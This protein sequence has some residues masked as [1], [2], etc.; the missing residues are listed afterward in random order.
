MSLCRERSRSP[1]GRRG[2]SADNVFSIDVECVATGKTHELSARSP[3]S[4]ALVDGSGKVIY[5]AMI[6]PVEPVVSYLTPITGVTAT[7]LGVGVPLEEAI[8]K[9]KQLLPRNATLVGQ[10]PDSDVAGMKLKR[11]IDYAEL[12]DVG[13]FFKGYNARFGN[14]S[15]HSLQHEAR[16]LLG[17]C[18]PAGAHDPVW[19]AQVSV[20][21]YKLAKGATPE[22]LRSMQ[23]QLISQR[24]LPS[25]AK[26]HNY[27]MDGVCLAKFMPK[28]CICGKPCS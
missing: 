10:N 27:R 13:S 14:F 21:L 2:S 3:C 20:D 5:K 18:A 11:G 7:D 24:P 28:F 25:V 19:D 17:K 9:L 15:V 1:A 8:A 4:V 12:V 23:Q 22:R 6:K 16:V 26:Q